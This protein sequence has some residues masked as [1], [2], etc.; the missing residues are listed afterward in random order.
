MMPRLVMML[1]L[2]P[3]TMPLVKTIIMAMLTATDVVMMTTCYDIDTH[4]DEDGHR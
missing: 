4:N 3:M 1:M 2:M